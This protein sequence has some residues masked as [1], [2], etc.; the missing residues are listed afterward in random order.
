[1]KRCAYCGT[2]N[3]VEAQACR[4]CGN[5][6]FIEPKQIEGEQELKSEDE[7]YVGFRLAVAIIVGITVTAVSLL[8]AWHNAEVAVGWGGQ[9]LTFKQFLTRHE[10]RRMLN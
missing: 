5:I 7:S 2:E 8:V 3:P 4:Q 9:Q 1:M 10:F 6:S